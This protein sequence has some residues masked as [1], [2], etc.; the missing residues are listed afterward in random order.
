MYVCSRTY[1]ETDD[2]PQFFDVGKLLSPIW[3][4]GYE[5][6]I[7]GYT[8]NVDELEYRVPRAWTRNNA[9]NCQQLQQ[10]RVKVM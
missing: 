3:R 4:E 5:E 1:L 10:H 6:C 8:E 9:F 7:A 2:D